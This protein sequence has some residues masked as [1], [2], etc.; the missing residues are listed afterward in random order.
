MSQKISLKDAERKAFKFA[1]QDGLWDILL[2]CFTLMFAIAPL[3]SNSLGD[4]WSSA[5]FLPFWALAYLIIK[6]VRKYVIKPRI[7]SV[8]FGPSRIAKLLKF[9][10]LTTVVLLVT[11][12]LGILSAINFTTLSGWTFPVGFGLGILIGFTL[13]GYFL[14]FPELYFYGLLI[15]LSPIAGEWLYVNLKVSHHGFPIAFG[16]TTLIILTIGLFKFVRLLREYPPFPSNTLSG[17]A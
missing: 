15:A 8:K 6:L 11:F 14:E 5:I 16:T 17:A 4:F 3:L 9:N 13:A 7:G 2:A 1:F 10:L 12:I